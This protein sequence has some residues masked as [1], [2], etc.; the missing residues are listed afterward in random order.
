[1]NGAS[2]SGVRDRSVLRKKNLKWAE[3][4]LVGLPTFLRILVLPSNQK[5]HVKFRMFSGL[6]YMY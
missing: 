1:M 4:R 6:P 3:I 5:P 2:G